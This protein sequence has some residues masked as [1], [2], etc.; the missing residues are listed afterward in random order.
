MYLDS[1]SFGKF[2]FGRR[3]DYL[4]QRFVRNSTAYMPPKTKHML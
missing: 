2:C 1:M 4:K 3:F